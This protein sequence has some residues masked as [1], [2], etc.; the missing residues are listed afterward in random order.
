MNYV[1]GIFLAASLMLAGC[2]DDAEQE[3]DSQ[4]NASQTKT[5]EED[6]EQR[7]SKKNDEQPT[8]ATDNPQAPDTSSLT[9]VG[10]YHKDED[11]SATLE[12][13]STYNETTQIGD[14]ELTISDVKVL[15]YS[16]SM[17]L[18]D[19][20][21]PYSDNETNFNYVKLHVTVEN[22]S[23]E[24]VDFAPV[25]V[26]ETNAGEKKDF[27]GDFYLEEL[28]GVYEGNEE[29]SGQMGFV[30]NDTEIEKLS[31]ITVRTSDVFD[32]DKTSQAKAKTI[33]IP[34]E[35]S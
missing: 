31:T 20:F 1:I 7:D 22:T 14:V 35:G 21:H 15:N 27:E 9:E 3:S 2:A 18:I 5:K 8:K 12:A 24:P 16:P 13:R 4:E 28:Y 11:G 10:D 23:D 30:L 17:D 25:S 6:K 32:E 33:E 34:I 19:F 29:R 26:L